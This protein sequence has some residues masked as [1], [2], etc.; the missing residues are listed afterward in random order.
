MTIHLQNDIAVLRLLRTSAFICI[1][2]PE[3]VEWHKM[4]ILSFWAKRYEIYECLVVCCAISCTEYHL[5]LFS[6]LHL[7]VNHCN[8]HLYYAVLISGITGVLKDMVHAY[9]DSLSYHLFPSG[10]RI[11]YPQCEIALQIYAEVMGRC[12]SFL[13]VIRN[14]IGQLAHSGWKWE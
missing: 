13:P 3:L 12:R 7:A 1:Q 6:L 11:Q 4:E 10:W 2:W 8:T 5:K 9:I 14:D